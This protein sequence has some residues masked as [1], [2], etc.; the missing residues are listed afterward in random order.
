MD[1]FKVE[2]KWFIDNGGMILAVSDQLLF[3][4]EV[5]N[6]KVG[7]E[8]TLEELEVEGIYKQKT[9]NSFDDLPNDCAMAFKLK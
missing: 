8:Y 7:E 3:Y 1:K 9:F 5:K 2:Q 4:R 6:I